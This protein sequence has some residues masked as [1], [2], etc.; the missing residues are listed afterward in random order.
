VRNHSNENEYH[1]HVHFHVNQSHFHVK[2]FSRR[3]VLKPRHNLNREWPIECQSN[4]RCTTTPHDWLKKAHATFFIQLENLK[5]KPIM[6]RSH[7]FSRASSQVHVCTSSFDWSTR[8]PVSFVIS[9]RDYI[10]FAFTTL[11]ALY[12]LFSFLT[13]FP[14]HCAFRQ[15][16]WKKP[17][18]AVFILTNGTKPL[19]WPSSITSKRSTP[20]LLST[21]LTC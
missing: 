20:F 6:T 12:A 13:H 2:G 1:L 7:T 19:N 4:W 15:G 3:L 17:L 5:P 14:M 18:T 21:P 10:G 9:W 8:L 16:K 11:A